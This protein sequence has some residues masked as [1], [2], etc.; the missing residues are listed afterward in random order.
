[1]LTI[2]FCLPDSVPWRLDQS[3]TKDLLK[4]VHQHPLTNDSQL[5]DYHEL[6]PEKKKRTSSVVPVFWF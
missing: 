6:K 3:S 1:M 4:F 2:L 5:C